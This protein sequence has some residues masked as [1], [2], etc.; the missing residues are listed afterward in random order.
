M[1]QRCCNPN[2]KGF[3]NYGGRGVSICDEWRNDY[4]LFHEW[5]LASG[6]KQGLMIERID[7]DAGYSPNNCTFA[8]RLQQNRNRRMCRYVKIDGVVACISEHAERK[9]INSRKFLDYVNKGAV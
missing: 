9:G 2:N 6:Y 5:A 4:Q 3:K 7:N 8:T 1:V